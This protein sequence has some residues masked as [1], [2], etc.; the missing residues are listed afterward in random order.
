MNDNIRS[1]E[2]WEIDRKAHLGRFQGQG[3]AQLTG[4][5][6][7][8][9]LL[10]TLAGC[11]VMFGFVGD[12]GVLKGLGAI[13]LSWMPLLGFVG[14][15]AL[16]RMVI[17]KGEE[18]KQLAILLN[19]PSLEESCNAVYRLSV[20][21]AKESVPHLKSLLNDD[22]IDPQLKEYAEKSLAKLEEEE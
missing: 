14:L 9:A 3:C 16:Y 6:G 12:G 22:T 18:K 8:V 13:A 21:K 10:G 2:Q 4:I 1:W 15:I 20:I 17:E 5:F 19:D 7:F 11:S